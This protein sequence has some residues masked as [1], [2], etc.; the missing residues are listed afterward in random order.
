MACQDHIPR[1]GHDDD[2]TIDQS[3]IRW[4]RRGGGNER[5]RCV[6]DDKGTVE[7]AKSGKDGKHTREE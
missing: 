5:I 2:D 3:T 6:F 4:L 1:K 7:V